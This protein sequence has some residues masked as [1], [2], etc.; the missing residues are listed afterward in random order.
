MSLS[1]VLAV[2]AVLSLL[3]N[4]FFVGTAAAAT[5]PDLRSVVTVPEGNHLVGDRITVDAHRDQRR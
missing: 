3:F 5:G 4:G 2:V 1:R